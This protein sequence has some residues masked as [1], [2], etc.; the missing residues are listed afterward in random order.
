M[1]TSLLLTAVLCFGAACARAGDDPFATALNTPST[2]WVVRSQS[3]DFYSYVS[4]STPITGSYSVASAPP[5]YAQGT[6]DPFAYQA[7]PAYP[8][9]IT[10]DPWAGGTMQPYAAPGYPGPGMSTYGVNG[11]RPRRYGWE[12]RYDIWWAPKT[13]TSSPDSGD[14]GILGV[15]VEAALTENFPPGTPLTKITTPQFSYRSLEGPEVGSPTL[16]LP[17]GAYRFG[18]GLALQT[19]TIGGWTYE[20]GFTPSLASDFR[21]QIDMDAVLLDGHAVAYWQMTPQW[22]WAFGV[23]YWDRVDD[24]VIPRAG[25]VY[26]PNSLWELR[27]LFPEARISTFVGTPFGVPM[28]LYA[29]LEYHVEA[30]QLKPKLFADSERTQFED[31]RLTGGLRWEAGPVTSFIEAGWIFDRNVEYRG[32]G[33]DFNIDDGFIGRIGFRY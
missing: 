5:V 18:L 33:S 24:I 32:A 22:M 11:V 12:S 7:T 23:Q 17:G 15:D 14:L 30:Y 21:S 6:V 13:G 2:E 31:W 25:V 9:P 29:G 26:R 20:I 8:A 27:L 4:T 1:K 3:P 19:P 10:Q 28:W 16:D